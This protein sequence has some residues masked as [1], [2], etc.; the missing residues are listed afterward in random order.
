MKV[1]LENGK[2]LYI[3]DE[4]IGSST[5]FHN[6]KIWKDTTGDELLLAMAQRINELEEEL[7]SAIN[8]IEESGVD[9]SEVVE[10]YGQN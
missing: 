9:Y 2:Y 6:G 10:Y 8:I 4:V 3:F 1:E 7:D 5:V